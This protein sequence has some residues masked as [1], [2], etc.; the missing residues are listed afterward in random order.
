VAAARNRRRQKTSGMCSK[1]QLLAIFYANYC[2]IYVDIGDFGKNNDASIYNNSV[3]NRKLR[4]GSLDVPDA[5]FLPG[6]SDMKMPFVLVR[7][8]ALAMTN[9]MLR[10]YGGK[11]VCENKCSTIDCRERAGS[12]NVPLVFLRINGEFS[13]DH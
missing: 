4:A 11:N 6:K 9:A 10:L 13:T 8:E 12:L 5:T 3:F 7:D 1:L 2:F